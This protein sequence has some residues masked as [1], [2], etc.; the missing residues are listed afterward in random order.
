MTLLGVRCAHRTSHEPRITLR[1]VGGRP[2]QL[3]LYRKR[4]KGSI[5]GLKFRRE[6][7][8]LSVDDLR[9]WQ[10]VVSGRAV[11]TLRSVETRPLAWGFVLSYRRDP[12]YD[13]YIKNKKFVLSAR[14]CI[15][16]IYGSFHCFF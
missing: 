8:E 11:S 10:G 2:D 15:L 7:S 4:S 1:T 6:D 16:V 3:V 9:T 5:F 12:V 14:M 13:K